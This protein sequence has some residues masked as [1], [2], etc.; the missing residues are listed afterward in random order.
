MM[1]KSPVQ[2][3]QGTK[4]LAVFRV[5]VAQAECDPWVILTA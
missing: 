4:S 3:L 2:N 5:G 1:L